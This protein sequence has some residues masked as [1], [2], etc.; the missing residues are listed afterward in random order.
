LVDNGIFCN[1]G[2]SY[3]N[4]SEFITGLFGKEFV[5]LLDEKQK[6]T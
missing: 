6:H 2:I 4:I 1:G 3:G 5:I